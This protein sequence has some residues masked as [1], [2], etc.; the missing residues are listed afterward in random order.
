MFVT[1]YF[2]QM[3]VSGASLACYGVMAFQDRIPC[4]VEDGSNPTGLIS[5]SFIIGFSLHAV[6]F[7]VSTFVEPILRA[8]LRKKVY[9]E[10]ENSETRRLFIF[11]FVVEHLFRVLFL[12]FSIYQ[13]I[14][15]GTPGVTICST[16]VNIL[17]EEVKWTSALAISQ[18]VQVPFFTAWR[19]FVKFDDGRDSTGALLDKENNTPREK[20]FTEK[21][22]DEQKDE[23]YEI[24]EKKR[25]EKKKRGLKMK[26]FAKKFK[27]PVK[28][29]NG[30]HEK[31]KGD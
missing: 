14:I 28:M 31:G 21:P 6:S 12:A 4:K 26:S 10:G 7:I 17:T 11:G 16:E 15:L 29:I 8:T 18:L 20:K 30:L 25:D 24:R 5:I 3:I 19:W 23:S 13:L 9:E 1:Y 2:A 22:W 27:D